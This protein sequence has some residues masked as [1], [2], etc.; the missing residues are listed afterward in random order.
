MLRF[1]RVLS[2]R[3]YL[4]AVSAESRSSSSKFDFLLVRK[5]GDVGVYG[6]VLKLYLWKWTRHLSVRFALSG[7]GQTKGRFA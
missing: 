7:G 4:R 5:V 6:F 1:A 3:R 2:R